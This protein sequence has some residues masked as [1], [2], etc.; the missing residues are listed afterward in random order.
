ME[1]DL[2]KLLTE[3]L[4]ESRPVQQDD[5]GDNSIAP[6]EPQLGSPDSEA[7]QQLCISISAELDRLHSFGPPI[8]KRRNTALNL[9]WA[10]VTPGVSMNDVFRRADCV[11]KNVYHD[12]WKHQ[13]LFVRVVA[14][15]SALVKEYTDNSDN[16][17][18]YH[19]RQ[20][21][22]EETYQASISGIRGARYILQMPHIHTTH[23]AKAG[24]VKVEPAS[25]KDKAA[26]ALIIDRLHRNGRLAIGLSTEAVDV[27]SGGE[28]VKGYAN[29]S[30]DDWDENEGSD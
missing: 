7:W 23:D 14:N 1:T 5:S 8:A 24:T 3:I 25:M 20:E 13:A 26:A 30:P 16:R 15:L 28:P 4:E 29:A 2:H 21:L 12:K 11:S 22:A 27:T 19:R 18:L 10:S 9:A 17:L 6:P